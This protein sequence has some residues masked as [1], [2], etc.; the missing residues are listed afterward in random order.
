MVSGHSTLQAVV[1]PPDVMPFHTVASSGK[2]AP[3]RYG[4]HLVKE[5]NLLSRA[6]FGKS[7]SSR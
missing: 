5:K 6:T 3:C 7:L 4:H 2:T 1:S